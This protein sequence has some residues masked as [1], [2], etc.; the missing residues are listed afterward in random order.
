M[1]VAIITITDGQNYGNRL[2]NYALQKTLRDLGVEV[3]T[4]RRRTHRDLNWI[5]WQK[6]KVKEYVK[7]IVGRNDNLHKLLRKKSFDSFNKKYMKFSKA[8]LHSNFAPNGFEHQYDYFIVG[9]DQVW[10]A[11][12]RIIRE[13]IMNYLLSFAPNDKR[14]AYAASFGTDRLAEGFEQLFK[15][16]LPKFNA[17]SVREVSGVKIVKECGKEAEVVLDPTMLLSVHD[18]TKMARRPNYVKDTPFI[19]TYFLGGRDETAQNYISNIAG[20]K[21]IYNIEIESAPSEAID[22]VDVFSTSPD[23]FVWLIA[24]A[25][26]VLT[27]SFHATAFSILFHKPFCVFERK[28]LDDSYKIGSRIDTLLGLFHLERFR[29]ADYSLDIK[30]E[31]YEAIDIERLLKQERERSIEFLRRTLKIE[32]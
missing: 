20:N 4:I 32:D 24:N 11:G 25:D 10:N 13:D 17:I 3:E 22:S 26:C 14:I 31:K 21:K 18:W 8:V 7:R 2:Q 19:V 28:V 15:D 5:G 9:S 23:E 16:E 12:F 1:K 29:N 27:D 6:W 30:P